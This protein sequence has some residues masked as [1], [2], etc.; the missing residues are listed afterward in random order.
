[1]KI[2]VCGLKYPDNF[3]E[4]SKLKPDYIGFICYKGTP[5]FIGDLPAAEVAKLPH[6]IIKTG[7]FVNETMDRIEE[8]IDTYGFD[9]IQLHGSEGADLCGAFKGKVIVIKAFGI[10]KDFNFDSLHQYVGDVDYFLFDTKTSK[11]GGSGETFDWSLLD[12]YKL[13]IPFFL[14]GGI[15]LDNLNE[16]KNI[17]HPQF[18]GVDLNSKFEME[19]GLKDIDKLRTAL[20][21][22]R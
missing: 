4:V 13:D 14:S 19:P 11:H 12:Q 16:V 3:R 7:V 20:E 9:A 18:Y 6:K 17:G 2:K 21:I 15:S 22:L 10:S 5:R 1:M 8:L